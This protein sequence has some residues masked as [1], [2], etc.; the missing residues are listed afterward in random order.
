MTAVRLEIYVEP[1][2]RICA[3]SED[4]AAEIRETEPDLDVE[5]IDLSGPDGAHRHFVVAAPTYVLNGRVVSLGNPDRAELAREIAVARK[6][7][8]A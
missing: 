1:G 7:A 3:R 8:P 4:I 6:G 2:C 5:V